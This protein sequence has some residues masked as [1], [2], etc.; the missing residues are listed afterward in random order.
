MNQ[1]SDTLKQ[2]AAKNSAVIFTY[3]WKSPKLIPRKKEHL[4]VNQ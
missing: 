1:K 2:S 4:K 3:D